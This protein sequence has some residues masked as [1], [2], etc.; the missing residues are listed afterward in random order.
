MRRSV[1]VALLF[2]GLLGLTLGCGSNKPVTS[3]RAKVFGT[4]KL[5][6]KALASGRI[7]FDPQN[8]EPPGDVSILDG[9]YEGMAILGKNKVMI[10]SYTKMTMKEKT[11]RDG[12]GYNDLV[13]FNMLPERYN[14]KSD[15]FREIEEKDNEINFD[16]KSK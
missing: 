14:M 11:G 7:T 16:I 5:D 15:V 2:C 4:I 10:N 6:G 3:K 12:P 1:S 13:E 9:R 8:G